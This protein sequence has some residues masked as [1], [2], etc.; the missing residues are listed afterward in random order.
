MADSNI[1]LEQRCA[2]SFCFKLGQNATECHQN[3]KKA[4]GENA[5]GRSTVFD[6][7]KRLK[8]GR[9]ELEDYDRSGRPSTSVNDSN[10]ERVRDIINTDRRLTIREI[11]DD[12]GLS[13]GTV[14]R[15]LTDK[16]G[17]TRVAAKFVPKLL[18]DEQ[19]CK[20][21]TACKELQK[22]KGKHRN[23]LDL[24]I[25]GDESWVYGYDP[26]TKQQS[27]YWKNPES[28]RKKKARM[29]RANFK[30]LLTLFF[31]TQGLVHCEYAPP[32]QTV[33]KQYYLEVLKRLRDAV[34][35][36][37]PEKW[38]SGKWFLHHDNAPAHTAA[39]IQDYLA[40]HHIR[41]VPQ[42][43]YSP[44]LA[45][46]DFYMFPRLKMTLKGHRFDDIECIQRNTTKEL[47]AFHKDDFKRCMDKWEQR[48]SHCIEAKGEYFEGDKHS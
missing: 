16:L 30:T 42:P 33:N 17:M 13:Y 15:I 39:I 46:C 36:K 1:L 19:K 45:P 20:R 7:Y 11:S 38:R 26:E 3:L 18:S 29:S 25:T 28:P 43:P 37:R 35:R 41:T 47:R 27:S 4:Y 40:K 21:V 22:L 44:D 24:V 6:W 14:Q 10:I 2:I 48:W 32:G 9:T 8:D 23:F 12:L 34:R 31:D 5:L